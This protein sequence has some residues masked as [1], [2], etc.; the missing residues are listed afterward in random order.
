MEDNIQ[1]LSSTQIPKGFLPFC[2]T[3]IVTDSRQRKYEL[4]A[5][6]DTGALVTLM[7]RK[8]LPDHA[9]KILD[10]ITLIRGISGNEV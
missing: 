10:Q 7:K 6:V 9:M 3:A 8:A 4:C 2:E 1:S 5:L